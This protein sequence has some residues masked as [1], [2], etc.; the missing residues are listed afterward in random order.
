MQ[1]ARKDRD[2]L[3]MRALRQRREE[4][5]ALSAVA[6]AYAEAQLMGAQEELEARLDTTGLTTAQTSQFFE[7]LWSAYSDRSAIEYTWNWP[8]S[9]IVA[10][11]RSELVSNDGSP[12][13]ER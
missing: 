10:H 13:I 6:R 3:R 4:L 12:L 2:R 9:R 1:Q 7:L 8:L 11:C 5:L